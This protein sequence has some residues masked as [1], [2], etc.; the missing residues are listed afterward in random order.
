MPNSGLAE[1]AERLN[2]PCPPRMHSVF[3]HNAVLSSE[4]PVPGE[5][6]SHYPSAGLRAYFAG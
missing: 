6:P 3:N 5:V 4:L 2:P 1:C